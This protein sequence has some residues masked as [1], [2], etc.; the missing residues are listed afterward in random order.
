MGSG[1]HSSFYPPLH[2]P[3]LLIA[4]V[5]NSPQYNVNR[6]HFSCSAKLLILQ[7]MQDG[8]K[9]LEV[10]LDKHF[11]SKWASGSAGPSQWEATR[12]QREAS[13]N[14]KGLEE[15]LR[16]MGKPTSSCKWPH[17][18]AM[19]VQSEGCQILL[20]NIFVRKIVPLL[21]QQLIDS[22]FILKDYSTV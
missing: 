17:S 11:I 19:K 15:A 14:L 18:S 22:L 4:D 5:I 21:D 9:P 1:F 6:M 13:L 12:F 16:K 3:I 10:I 8:L 20:Q 7:K 2:Q